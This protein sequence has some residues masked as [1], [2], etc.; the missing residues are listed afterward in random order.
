MKVASGIILCER[1][2][3]K[4]EKRRFRH[5]SCIGYKLDF[6]VELAVATKVNRLAFFLPKR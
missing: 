3:S 2:K 5:I 6:K 4:W 1:L